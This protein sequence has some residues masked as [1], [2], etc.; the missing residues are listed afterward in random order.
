MI[1]LLLVVPPSGKT[2]EPFG[3]QFPLQCGDD[4]SVRHLFELVRG[5]LG[6]AEIRLSLESNL[7]G[8]A[9]LRALDPESSDTL[10]SSDVHTGSRIIVGFN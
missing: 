8:A 10:V 3:T 7:G 5:R 4:C 1:D 9:A 2:E 6:R